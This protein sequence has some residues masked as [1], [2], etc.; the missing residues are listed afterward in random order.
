[1][2]FLKRIN[3]TRKNQV[4]VA[5]QVFIEAIFTNSDIFQARFMFKFKQ[6]VYS[7]HNQLTLGDSENIEKNNK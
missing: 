1:M 3:Q 4:K 6:F 2:N 5:L 7:C